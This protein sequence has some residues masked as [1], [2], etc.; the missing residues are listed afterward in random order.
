ML[1]LSEVELQNLKSQNAI[2][3]WGCRRTLHYAF[4]EHGMLMLSSVLNNQTAIQVNIQ[5]MRV[6]TKIR[7]MI[8]SRKDVLLKLESLGKT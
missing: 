6:Y 4:T 3:R 2:S 1:Q 7:E 5:I 8:L